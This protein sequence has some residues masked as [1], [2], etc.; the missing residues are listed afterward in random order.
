M[1]S[2]I[3]YQLMHY[4]QLYE[5]YELKHELIREYTIYQLMY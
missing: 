1:V 5:H 3:E 2:T 4:I